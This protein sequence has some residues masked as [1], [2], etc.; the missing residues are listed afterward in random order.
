ME[1][2][3]KSPD[4]NE[5]MGNKSSKSKENKS[6]VHVEKLESIS[7]DMAGREKEKKDS[8]RT[9][10]EQ[11][12]SLKISSVDEST[13]S[14]LS[15]LAEKLK[16]NQFKNVVTLVGA[17]I[18]T[19]AGIPDF[20][21][22]GTGLYDNL[23]KFNL[24]YSEAIFELDYFQEKPEP[25][26]QLARDLMPGTFKPTKSHYFIK[27]LEE[28]GILLRHYTQ[29]IDG[30]ERLAGVS[31]EK[32]IEAH[33]T[34]YTSHCTNCS[35]EYSFD[36]MKNAIS[37]KPVPLCEKCHHVVK[38]DIIFFGENLPVEFFVKAQ[39]DFPK[40]DLLIIMGSSLSVQP[41]ASLVTRVG[42]KCPRLIINKG[43]VG[44]SLGISF[45][46]SS[47]DIFLDGDCDA[48]VV[49]L[50]KLAGW[51]A[52]LAKLVDQGRKKCKT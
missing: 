7:K 32:M 10:E 19:S 6:D 42:K 16:M 4:K 35:K 29:N 3:E 40:C 49:R 48:S 51:D 38:P 9:L 44:E 47:K 23:K 28:K 50:A 25:F 43:K 20:R 21:S 41:V 37:A 26:F 2:S 36:W 17:G 52:D 13:L 11:L 33:G 45:K 8:S 24:P 30:L 15:S 31:P 39:K 18:S 5:D 12:A 46:G 1:S 27:L 22:P 34:F 14:N